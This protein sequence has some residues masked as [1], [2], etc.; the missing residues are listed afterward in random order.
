M[1]DFETVKPGTKLFIPFNTYDSNDPSASVTI[2]GLA[3]TDIEIYKDESVT[4]RASDSGYALIDT[5]GIDI[6]GITGI[7]EVSVDLADNTTVG[8]YAGGSRYKVVIAGITVDGATVNFIAAVFTIGYSDAILNTTIASLSSQTSFTLTKG[9]AENDALNDRMC[10]IHDVAS[11]VQV[12]HAVISDYVGST[13][14][15][16]LAAGTTF[17]AA[18][19]DNISIMGLAPL[20]PTVAGAQT[21]VQTADHT[22]AIAAIP[23][24]AMR[25]TDS[26]LLASSAPTNFGAMGIE[27]DGDLT[28]VNLLDGNTPQT[29]DHTAAIAA[30]PTTAMRG[31]DSAALASVCTEPRLAELDA[32]NMP[33]DID[34]IPTTAMRG[35]DG[36]DTATMRGTDGVD[37]ATMRGTDGANTVVPDPA[38][39]APTLAEMQTTALTESYAANGVEPTQ[40]Q[41]LYAIHQMLMEFGIAGTSLTVKK[42]DSATTA[43]VVTLDDAT[44][45]TSATR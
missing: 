22:S 12:G 37:T 29:A 43:F 18:A 39:T 21:V 13:K 15:V 23:T 11:E 33:A 25:G 27:S 35:T 20:Q 5:D 9:P 45:P 44:N 26:A 28:K 14:T 42:L 17:T 38:G 41:L 7:H 6:D 36:V 2:T 3:V 30:I 4:Q 31:T 34:A 1:R 8:F 16:T 10:V 32:A 19:T 24:T 40:N